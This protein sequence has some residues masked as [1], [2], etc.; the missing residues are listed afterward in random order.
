MRVVKYGR[1]FLYIHQSQPANR[2]GAEVSPARERR[3]LVQLGMVEWL[4]ERLRG[5]DLK[6]LVLAGPASYRVHGGKAPAPAPIRADPRGVAPDVFLNGKPPGARA[7][8]NSRTHGRGPTP[9]PGSVPPCGQITFVRSRFKGLTVVGC[10]LI[11]EESQLREGSPAGA[12]TP[13]VNGQ[14]PGQG[15]HGLFSQGHTCGHPG[16]E[17]AAGVPQWLITQQAP[18]RLDQQHPD[19]FIAMAVNAALALVGSAA[20]FAGTTAGVAARS[21]AVFEAVPVA[22]FTIQQGQGQSPQSFGE[23]FLAD[24]SFDLFVSCS[25]W[26]LAET[27]CW[28]SGSRWARKN[29]ESAGSSRFHLRG[30]A[31]PAGSV[32]SS[33]SRRKARP[34]FSSCRTCLLQNLRWRP[35][36]RR[37]CSATLGMRMVGSSSFCPSR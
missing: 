11:V 8:S 18:D 3:G 26:A 33:C 4:G 2:S 32:C 35:S 24:P 36:S 13:E 28:R 16:D 37:C 22:D 10:G 34:W 25:S 1:R 6:A 9:A 12:P 23:S 30:P 27:I 7:P 19:M 20:V 31:Q 21:L 17:F 5:S 29:A 15:H 14:L